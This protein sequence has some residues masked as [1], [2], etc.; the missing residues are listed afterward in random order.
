MAV[1]ELGRQEFIVILPVIRARWTKKR[2]SNHQA[3]E[4]LKD[5]H[6]IELQTEPQDG[7]G[8]VESEKLKGPRSDGAEHKQHVAA[9]LVKLGFS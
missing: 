9:Q 1:A 3:V 4:Q 7:V 8:S 6:A 5:C 2:C